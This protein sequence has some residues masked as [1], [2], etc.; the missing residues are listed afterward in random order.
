[1]CVY[2]QE[3]REFLKSQGMPVTEDDVKTRGQ[4]ELL[5]AI[6]STNNNNG[7]AVEEE[8]DGADKPKLAREG[9]MAVTA[10]VIFK[11][12]NI[13]EIVCHYSSKQI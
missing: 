11:F 10:K 2:N 13:V 6:T 3:G 7:D 4:Q 12:K 1:M 9:T 8:Q 5:D